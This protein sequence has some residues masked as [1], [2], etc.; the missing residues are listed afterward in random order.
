MTPKGEPDRTKWMMG[1]DLPFKPTVPMP[2]WAAALSRLIARASAIL[3]PSTRL[4]GNGSL[5]LAD[6]VAS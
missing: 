1:M 6:H 4:D 3:G 5:V 2:G